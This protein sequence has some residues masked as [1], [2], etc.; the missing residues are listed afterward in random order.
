VCVFILL[1]RVF[2]DSL[3]SYVENVFMQIGQ[4]EYIQHT[5]STGHSFRDLICR[6]YKIF[7][8]VNI[9]SYYFKIDDFNIILTTC[10][11]NVSKIVIDV[12][13]TNMN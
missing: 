2:A 4:R 10:V 11:I 3:C 8:R 5:L 6:K 1:D 13:G 7:T 12:V 9:I